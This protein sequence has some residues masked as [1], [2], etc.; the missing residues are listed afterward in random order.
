MKNK[1]ITFLIPSFLFMMMILNIAMPDKEISESERRKLKQFPTLNGEFTSKFDNYALD[2]FVFRDSFRSLKSY[3]NLYLLQMKDNN[4]LVYY[5]DYIYKLDYKLD[6][7]S[8]NNFTSIINETVQKYFPTNKIYY[9]VIPDKS[10]FL[11]EDYPKLDYDLLYK[12]VKD[13]LNY[14][15]IDIKSLLNI[16]DYYKTDMHWK[17]DK[18]LKV[19]NELSKTMGFTNQNNY[20]IKNVGTFKGVYYSQLGLNIKTDELNYLINENIN[21]SS[22]NDIES[23][24]NKVYNLDKVTS[25]EPYDLFLNGASPLITINN[26]NHE[27]KELIIFRDSFGS[28]ITPLLISS[29]SKITLIDLRYI[30][31]ENALNYLTIDNQDVLFLY[32]TI[33]INNSYT[34]KR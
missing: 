14:Q 13:A 33:L 1:V 26:P 11:P 12:E 31:M 24:H 9:S 6:S 30:N 10:Y 25:F 7:K 3:Y 32:S 16:N 21:T 4:N 29:Y 27:Q 5:N 22:I 2:Q 23:E 34:L 17:Q 18:I 20:Q 28:S 19:V 8:I 15:Y